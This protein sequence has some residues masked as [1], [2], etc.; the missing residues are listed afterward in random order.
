MTAVAKSNLFVALSATAVVAF[1]A[2][3]STSDPP[4]AGDAGASSSSSSSSSSSGGSSGS[5][6]AGDGGGSGKACAFNRECPSAERCE[7]SESAGCVCK[8]GPRGTGKNGV[9][10][11]KDGNDCESSLCV[12]GPAS[13]TAFYCSDECTTAAQCKGALPVCADIALVGRICV[14]TP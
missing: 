5:S 2:C 1:T 6:G 7:C 12:E 9:D 13:G 11:C 4:A 3:S 10:T 8:T 14:R